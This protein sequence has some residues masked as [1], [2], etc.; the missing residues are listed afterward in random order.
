MPRHGTGQ[1]RLELPKDLYERAGLVGRPIR[2][3]GRKHIKAR[4]GKCAPKLYL[5]ISPL[6][7]HHPVTRRCEPNLVITA[8]VDVPQ[9]LSAGSA[10][11]PL[12]D[13]DSQAVE[14][15][16]WLNLAML[17][18]PRI[19]HN[20]KIDPYLC[21]YSQPTGESPDIGS[22]TE[23]VDCK[24]GYTILGLAGRNNA[25]GENVAAN[26]EDKAMP[27]GRPP[28]CYTLRAALV[29][30]FKANEE[31]PLLARY[32]CPHSSRRPVDI[33]YNKSQPPLVSLS[34]RLAHI[35]SSS[36]Y[37]DLYL[38]QR[39]QLTSTLTI[40][41]ETPS[42]TSSTSPSPSLQLTVQTINA[43]MARDDKEK[44]RLGEEK[45]RHA[46]YTAR[47][48][49]VD[50]IPD[51]KPGHTIAKKAELTSAWLRKTIQENDYLQAVLDA[52]MAQQRYHQ[53]HPAAR[54]STSQQPISTVP[55]HPHHPAAAA[56]AVVAPAPRPRPATG[57][58]TLTRPAGI[59]K[60]RGRRRKEPS[61]SAWE[62]VT[63][64]TINPSGQH[65]HIEPK[66]RAGF[67]NR[68]ARIV[69]ESM[70]S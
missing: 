32:L 22:L 28:G 25:E 53:H 16:E 38:L 47:D 40:T 24:D 66:G 34:P 49:M 60:P 21:R 42:Q 46:E 50:F 11:W 51:I 17:Q 41:T 5:D 23:V 27:H 36:T 19:Q 62:V 48:A 52:H 39:F 20:D 59:A 64:N 9:S 13:L 2:D 8:K 44:H 3:L 29:C 55:D 12:H 18:S 7:K 56:A 54:P 68:E 45:R 37:T 43:T 6:A 58:P 14:I 1:L 63:P 70:K 10:P 61:R 65:M 26:K 57:P 35:P 33:V 4:Y 15:D 31:V 69:P 67:R 30:L